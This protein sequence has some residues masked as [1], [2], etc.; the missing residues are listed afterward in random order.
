MVVKLLKD[1]DRAPVSQPP[2]LPCLQEQP[3]QQAKEPRVLPMEKQLLPA[4]QQQEQPKQQTK[5]DHALP[6]EKQPPDAP[7][8]QQQLLQQTREH[9][10]PSMN[11]SRSA[12]PC[13]PVRIV[14]RPIA[15]AAVATASAGGSSNILKAL[16]PMPLPIHTQPEPRQ[17][18]AAPTAP[19]KLPE[20]QLHALDAS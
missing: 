13:I 19:C 2:L 8:Q 5:Q 18:L 6:G 1:G 14:G 11:K 20:E 17:A 4:T 9:T 16:M 12:S 3:H 10:A 7:P 15:R